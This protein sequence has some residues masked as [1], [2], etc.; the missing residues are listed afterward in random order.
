M[1]PSCAYVTR[2]SS[3]QTNAYAVGFEELMETRL[4][5]KSIRSQ[6]V[7]GFDYGARTP[8]NRRNLKTIAVEPLS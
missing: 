8:M 5:L 6:T 3:L 1:L 2:N 4:K 7:C